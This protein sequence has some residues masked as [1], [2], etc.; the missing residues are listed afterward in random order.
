[1]ES[2][3]KAQVRRELFRRNIQGNY[4]D[5]DLGKDKK[6]SI[7]GVNPH[8]EDD[9]LIADIALAIFKLTNLQIISIDESAQSTLGFT[10][11]VNG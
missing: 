7:N 1:M 6:I 3:T 10:E 4:V 11:V 9:Q 5:S 2:E 8:I